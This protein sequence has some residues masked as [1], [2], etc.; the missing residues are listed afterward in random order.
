MAGMRLIQTHRLGLGYADA[1]G[2]CAEAPVMSHHAGYLTGSTATTQL[3][4][5]D[6]PLHDLYLSDASRPQ[7]CFAHHLVL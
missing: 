1:G 4:T 3:L 7:V 5:Y 2:G 6:N